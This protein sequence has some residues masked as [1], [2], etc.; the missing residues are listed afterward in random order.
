MLVG[1]LWLDTPL[2]LTLGCFVA[3]MAA[4]GLIWGNARR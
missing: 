1:A 3:F 4:L 2:L